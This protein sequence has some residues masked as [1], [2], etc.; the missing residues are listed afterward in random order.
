[1]HDMPPN[2]GCLFRRQEFQLIRIAVLQM[3]DQVL[4]VHLPLFEQG[5]RTRIRISIFLGVQDPD[6][7]V[8][9]TASDPDP[10]VIKQTW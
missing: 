10:F 8:C 9:G 2:P 6:P 5:L 3:G 4:P 1:M 7:L